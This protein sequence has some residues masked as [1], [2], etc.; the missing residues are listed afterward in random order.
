MF[1]KLIARCSWAPIGFGLALLAAVLLPVASAAEP[2]V[3][4]W[5]PSPDS[6]VTS[7]IVSFADVKTSAVESFSVDDATAAEITGL[8]PG[9]T[10]F[11]CVTAAEDSGAESEPSNVVFVTVPAEGTGTADDE[12][13]YEELAPY[14]EE[15]SDGVLSVLPRTV[16][17]REYQLRFDLG[18]FSLAGPEP[19]MIQVRVSG[20][21]LLVSRN[22]SIRAPESGL[23]W[24]SVR[25]NFVADGS[26]TRIDFEDI[27]DSFGGEIFLKEIRVMQLRL[28]RR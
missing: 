4:E 20:R 11:I 7:Y 28:R 1:L 16:A 22:Q 18:A 2:L 9:S 10:Y 25:L 12:P 26:S 27:S 24:V 8:Q 14:S 21:R 6:S 13:D 15:A 3:I 19:R 17:G 5:E 23:A